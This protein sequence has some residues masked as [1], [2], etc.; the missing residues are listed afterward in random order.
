MKPEFLSVL[1]ALATLSG[2]SIV[3]PEAGLAGPSF[4]APS[5]LRDSKALTSAIIDFGTLVADSPI[6][7]A[8]ETAWAVAVF[9][10]HDDEPLYE[11]YF[12]P[13][14]DVGVAEVNRS[15]VF[16]IASVSKVFSVWT[17]LAEVGDERFNDPITKYVPELVTTKNDSV[18]GTVYDDIDHVRW[19]EVTLGQLASQL[20]GIPRDP[21]QGDM[22]TELTPEQATAFGFPTLP[23]SDIPTCGVAGLLRTC[24][25]KEIIS[26]LLKQHPVFPTGHSPAYSNVA[27][28]LLGFAQEAI[29]GTPVSNAITTN[30]LSALKMTSSSFK[31]APTSGGVIPGEASAVGWDWDLGTIDPAGSMYCSTGDMVK[32]GQA[33]LG[34][35]TMTPAQTRRWLKPMSQTGVL[36]SAVGAP[37]EI[38]HLTVGGRLSQLYTKQGDTGGYR[39]AF[40]LSPEHDL[41]AVIFSASPLASNSAA[42]RETLMNA[43]GKAFL[44]MA[45]EQTR[46]EAC[47]NFAGTYTDEATNSSLTINVDNVTTGLQVSGFTSRGVE[48]IGPQSPFIPIYGAGQSARLFPSTLR[49]VRKTEDGAGTYTSR[50]GFR[51]SFF[52][53]TGG[54]NDVQDPGLMQWTS[55]GAPAYGERT[56]DDWVMEMGENG[57][58]R[59]VD[60]RMMRL[61]LEREGA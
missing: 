7:Q 39:A 25:R 4:P 20:A 33:I 2:Q 43:V 18:S 41:G 31:T 45:E 60:A 24:T 14:Y 17:F 49:T 11:R 56:L 32:A 58:A 38:R 27:Y 23:D 28:A 35:K 16:R 44:P 40:V 3:A 22:S 9:S 36:G 53:V 57:K 15:S 54:A 29:T 55:L 6:V 37:W 46:I 8:N 10:T 13:D 21:A 50:L 12:T 34:S 52:N 61:K 51:A 30:I 47:D 26:L 59:A 5:G 19:H 42:V 1:S 48:I